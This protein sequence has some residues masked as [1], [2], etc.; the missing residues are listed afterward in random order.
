[1]LIYISRVVASALLLIFRRFLGELLLVFAS[2]S[3]CPCPCLFLWRCGVK[4]KSLIF[5]CSSDGL[6]AW[7]AYLLRTEGVKLLDERISSCEQQ[8]LRTSNGP[9]P[10]RL[11][12]SFFQPAL[13]ETGHVSVVSMRHSWHVEVGVVSSERYSSCQN[14][15]YI[16]PPSYLSCY[17]SVYVVLVW[18]VYFSR[19]WPETFLPSL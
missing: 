2:I 16:S 18:V 13:D 17:S 10:N 3:P 11:C 1:M 12:L 9:I 6:H 8:H 7:R 14:Q 15:K 5:N 4:P 19:S